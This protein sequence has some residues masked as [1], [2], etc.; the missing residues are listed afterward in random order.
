MPSTSSPDSLKI[1]FHSLGSDDPLLPEWLDLYE[2]AF[3]P[4]QRV[5]VEALL[6]MMAAGEPTVAMLAVLEE[7][8]RLV[9]LVIFERAECPPALFLWYL[10]VIP[11]RRN[12]G[13]GAR[14][15]RRIIAEYADGCTGVVFDVEI[16]ELA[17]DPAVQALRARRIEF[18][19][20]L[21]ARLL[22]GIDYTVQA[23]ADY[24]PARLHVMLHP[25]EPLDDRTAFELARQV[26]GPD[27]LRANGE[28]ALV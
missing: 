11:E 20:R 24:P 28:P 5:P 4:D 6:S 19:R 21:G 16:P 1:S 10:A 25:L 3:P 18:Y 9:G 7:A 22:T 17:A 27:A 2:S 12:Q 15:Y 26:M 23:N 14:I 8:G 13:L